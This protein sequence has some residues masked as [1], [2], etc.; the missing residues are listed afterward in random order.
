M[1]SETS[2]AQ[3]TLGSGT[4]PVLQVW[5]Q[6]ATGARGADLGAGGECGEGGTCCRRAGGSGMDE[7]SWC[8]GNVKQVGSGRKSNGV[9]KAGGKVDKPMLASAGKVLCLQVPCH[10]WKSERY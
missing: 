9:G 8:W 10:V 3:D 1:Q 5:L 7:K 6:G 2:P 4:Y